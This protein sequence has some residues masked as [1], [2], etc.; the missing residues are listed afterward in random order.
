M[1]EAATFWTVKLYA[2]AKSMIWYGW[3][4]GW[5]SDYGLAIKLNIWPFT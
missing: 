3:V 1:N 4:A 5:P 2:N